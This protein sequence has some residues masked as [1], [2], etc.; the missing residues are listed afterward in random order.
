MMKSEK[1]AGQGHKVRIEG[2][3]MLQLAPLACY[4]DAELQRLDRVF[5]LL[6]AATDAMLRMRDMEAAGDMDAAKHAEKHYEHHIVQV[7]TAVDWKAGIS[8]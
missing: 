3:P 2:N 7:A 1:L 6:S 4:S 8:R 5:A